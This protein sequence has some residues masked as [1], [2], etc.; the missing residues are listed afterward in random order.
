MAVIDKKLLHVLKIDLEKHKDIVYKQQATRFFKEN[1]SLIG[2]RIAQVRKISN[3]YFQQIKHIPKQ[4]LFQWIDELL[5]REDQ[6]YKIAAFN[7]LYKIRKSFEKNDIDFFECCLAKYVTNWAICDD[8]CMHALGY[9]IYTYPE[10]I[11]QLQIWAQSSN[12][13]M[14]RAAAVSLIYG[15][16]KKRYLHEALSIA[17]IVLQD[18]DDLVQKG[19]GWML[20][21]AS[22]SYPQDV[23]AYV[24]K[25]KNLMPR[26][27]LRYAIEKLPIDQRKMLMQK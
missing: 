20:K 25:Y 2:V 9:F 22:K 16:N 21:V 6:E 5:Q 13:W 26:I 23:Y 15:L 3:F 27:A 18:T 24:E 4:T 7:W 8:L 10:H 17:D 1:I 19:Y 12:R 14:R 11:S